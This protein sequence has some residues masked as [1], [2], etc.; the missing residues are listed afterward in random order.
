[1]DF[2]SGGL[3]SPWIWLYRVISMEIPAWRPK[4]RYVSL[5][6]DSYEKNFC[7]ETFS[8]TQRVCKLRE[9]FITQ[10]VREEMRKVSNEFCHFH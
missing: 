6:N 5:K 4:W 9:K 1:M 10:V 7:P 2:P 3:M 8:L